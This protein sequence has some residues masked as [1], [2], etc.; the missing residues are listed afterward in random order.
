M[1]SDC[2]PGCPESSTGKATVL[3][4]MVLGNR[5]SPCKRTLSRQGPR[6]TRCVLI[7]DGT[8]AVGYPGN[9]CKTVP[10]AGTPVFPGKVSVC[11]GGPSNEVAPSP[12]AA[13]HLSH[14]HRTKQQRIGRFSPLVRRW[15]GCSWPQCSR[16]PCVSA[17]AVYT[18]GF[19]SLPDRR[20]M[21]PFT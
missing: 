2:P 6:W 9:W 4:K 12:V 11:V 5:L 7:V 20:L 21:G 18:G 10:G 16:V 1:V 17:G 15:D 13:S 19:Q 14:T 3:E 8:Q